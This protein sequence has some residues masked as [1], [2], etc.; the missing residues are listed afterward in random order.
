[1]LVASHFK[2]DPIYTSILFLAVLMCNSLALESGKINVRGKE[3]QILD[4]ILQHSSYDRRI[5]PSGANDT[6]MDGP[7]IVKINLMFRSFPTIS[8][9]K[10]EYSTIMTFREEW[11]DDRLKYDDYGGK[12]KYLTLTDQEKVWMPDLF[13]AN[14]R[15][16]HFHDIIVPNV[17]IRIFPNGKIL[18]SIRISLTLSCPMDLRLYPLDR[19]TC[20]LNMISYGWTTEDLIF[21]WRENEPVQVPENMKLP[22]FIVEK[23]QTDLCSSNTTTGMYSC[24]KVNLL[25]K[26]EF[27]YYLIQIYVP[28]C[29]L[30]IV[31]W[32]SFWLD[33]NAV[34]ARVSLGVTTL[35]TMA[36]QTTGINNSLPPVS[37]TK[38]IDVWTGVCLTFVFSALLEFALVNYA[39]RSDAHIEKIIKQHRQWE[40]ERE[41]ERELQAS[42]ELTANTVVDSR[43]DDGSSAC[44]SKKSLPRLRADC[45]SMDRCHAYDFYSGGMRSG[46]SHC[47]CTWISGFKMRSKRID[48]I[49]RII[50]PVMFA[51][52][53]LVYWTSYL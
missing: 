20:H 45:M 35:L 7:T 2:M 18:Y 22:R 34:P 41:R 48:V 50:F 28:C 9:Y 39:S 19:Q 49:A 3:K 10:M 37:Y 32:V 11:M 38:A 6:G 26:R 24:L 14:E 8:D 5:R 46:S 44:P 12:I 13:F 16:G 21:Q 15:E 23:V 53:N 47:S 40:M 36:T 30:V 25:F 27:S 43:L 42:M 29:M 31:S 17:Y 51:M 4:K 52:F 1:M 33:A